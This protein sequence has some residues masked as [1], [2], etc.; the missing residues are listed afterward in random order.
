M[1]QR[2]IKTSNYLFRNY[3]VNH[4]RIVAVLYAQN[5]K[6]KNIFTIIAK[7]SSDSLF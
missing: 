4:T 5:T 2:L 1:L 3:V 7:L 6:F